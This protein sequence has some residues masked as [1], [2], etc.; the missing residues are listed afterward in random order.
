MAVQGLNIGIDFTGGYIIQYP[1]D[2]EVTAAQ[3]AAIIND[4]GIKHQPVQ[5]TRD[6]MTQKVNGFLLRTEGYDKDQQEMF[7]KKMKA[8]K[9][10]FRLELTDVIAPVV[11]M[12][13]VGQDVTRQEVEK[14]LQKSFEDKYAVDS[15]EV[16]Q[17][18]VAEGE[19]PSYNIDAK[20]TGA[21]SKEAYNEVATSLYNEFGGFEPSAESRTEEVSPIF[22]QVLFHNA[23]YA[24]IIAIISILIYVWIRFELWFAIAAIIALIHDCLFTVGAFSVLQLEINVAFVAIILTVFGYSINDTIVIFDRIRENMRKDRRVSLATVMNTSLWETMPRSI[25]TTLTTQFTLLAII[26]LGGITIRDFS[27]GIFM[28][29]LAG[30]YSSIFVAAPVAYMLKSLRGEDQETVQQPQARSKKKEKKK[31]AAEQAAASKPA[32]KTASTKDGSEGKSPSEP[33]ASKASKPGSASSA[34]KK[35]KKQRRR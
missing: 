34:K 15:F 18:P 21:E 27:V 8:L 19:A 12:K 5:L 31:A 10:R 23:A 16:E 29:I 7:E 22:S 30:A 20:I 33:G 2:E 1:T 17:N 25:N 4:I 9:V 32:S 35:S 11:H 14:H 28:G 3:V 6:R 13:Y 26:F 24:L